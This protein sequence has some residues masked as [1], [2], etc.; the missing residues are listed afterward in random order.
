M[1][2]RVHWLLLTSVSLFEENSNNLIQALAVKS[3]MAV[4]SRILRTKVSLRIA[5]VRLI[6]IDTPPI[7]QNEPLLNLG[8]V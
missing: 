2:L 4:Q 3:R 5:M 8:I 1:I 7:I 6:K